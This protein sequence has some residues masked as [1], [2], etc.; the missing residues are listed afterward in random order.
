MITN[1]NYNY[2][3]NDGDPHLYNKIEKN[4]L[5]LSLII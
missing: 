5:Y 3:P 1:K 2:N 4:I